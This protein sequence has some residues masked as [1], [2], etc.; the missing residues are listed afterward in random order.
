M[1]KGRQATF[2]SGSSETCETIELGLKQVYISPQHIFLL[3]GVRRQCIL[4]KKL[5][6]F[7]HNRIGIKEEHISPLFQIN[8][9]NRL[10]QAY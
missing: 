5:E 9:V 4:Q 1:R 8:V 6:H 3:C 7:G 10:W 2:F